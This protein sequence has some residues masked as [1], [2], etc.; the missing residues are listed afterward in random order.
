MNKILLHTCQFNRFIF[1][2][3]FNK[4]KKNLHYS[5][6]YHILK[7]NTKLHKYTTTTTTNR[8]RCHTH[9]KKKKL[10]RNLSNSN[11]YKMQQF[12][13]CW[14]IYR[15]PFY[16]VVSVVVEQSC[17][18]LACL[19]SWHILLYIFTMNTKKNTWV[20]HLLCLYIIYDYFCTTT[21][22]RRVYYYHCIFVA[23]LF[24]KIYI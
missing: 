13:Q 20:Q 15:S 3:S 21:I 5:R 8:V 14:F 7:K 18:W 12:V 22:R 6:T 10:W 23:F 19:V 11:F 17:G 2:N 9:T 1:F 24:K 4:R 16:V